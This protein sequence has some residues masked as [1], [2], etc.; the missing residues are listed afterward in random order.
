MKKT[1]RTKT[2]DRGVNAH[3]GRMD[4]RLNQIQYERIQSAL[5]EHDKAVSEYERRWGVD[6]LQELVSP[7]LRERFYQQRERLNAAIDSND[8]KDV[9]HQ[10]QVSIRS[11]AAIEKAAIEAGAKPLTGEYWECPMPSGKVLAITRDV[12]EAGKVAR[13][14]REMVVYS[15]GEIANILDADLS[16]RAKKI[17]QVKSIFPGATVMDVK[18]KPK[19]EMIDD[20]IP[21]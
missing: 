11:Y 18:P 12:H 2:A 8:G 10:V 9:Q 14:N 3:M 19:V 20:E 17:E 7:E 1:T 5:T 13:E 6:R 15:I 4:V 21:F 16:E